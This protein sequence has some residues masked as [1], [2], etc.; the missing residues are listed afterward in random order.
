MSAIQRLTAWRRDRKRKRRMVMAMETIDVA[1]A[2][3]QSETDLIEAT[4]RL[5]DA[6]RAYQQIKD[7][8]DD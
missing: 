5:A 1:T 8:K 6:Q 7:D 4:R 2:L 3:T